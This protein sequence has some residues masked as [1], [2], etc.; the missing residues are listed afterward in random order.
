VSL[1]LVHLVAM[2]VSLLNTF[3]GFSDDLLRVEVL[4]SFRWINSL[5]SS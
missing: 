5:V 1:V 3:L 4:A 2:F